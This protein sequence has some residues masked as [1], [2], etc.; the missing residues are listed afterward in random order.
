MDRER[1][2]KAGQV[3][4]RPDKVRQGKEVILVSGTFRK[5]QERSIYQSRRMS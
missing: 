5:M 3:S 2:G 1:E 4:A